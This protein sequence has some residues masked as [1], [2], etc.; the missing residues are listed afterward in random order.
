MSVIPAPGFPRSRPVW[1]TGVMG[2]L[3]TQMSRAFVDNAYSSICNV[4]FSKVSKGGEK[5]E[6]ERE[7]GRKA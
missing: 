4:Q 1:I 2:E 5:E 6:W 7:K 3:R